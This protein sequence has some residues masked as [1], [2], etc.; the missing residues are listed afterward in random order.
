MNNNKVNELENILG[1]KFNNPK[2][3]IEALTHPSMSYKQKAKNRFNYERLEFLGDSILSTIISEYLFKKFPKEPEGVLS[4]KKSIL[5]SKDTLYKVATKINLGNYIIMTKG[6][7]NTN[8]RKNINNLENATE[9]II[10]AIFLDS[11]ENGLNNVRKF[12]LRAWADFLDCNLQYSTKTALQEWVQKKYKRLPEYKLEN[13]E[14]IDKQ[15]I[16]TVSL[17]VPNFEKITMSGKN[18]KNIEKELAVEI[19]NRINNKV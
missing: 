14:I 15:E 1:Y 11:E 3:L 13:T 19:L 8:G 17:K 5:V 9:A 10:G 6:E 18:I 12:I 16:F 2:Y 4:K 7:E